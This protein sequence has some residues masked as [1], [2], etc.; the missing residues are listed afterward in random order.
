[1]PNPVAYLMLLIWPF[2]CLGLFR[3][4][5]L[6]RALIWSILGGYLFLPPLAEFNL[7]LVPGLDKVSIPNLS[8]LLIIWL[9]TQ[10]KL[11]LWPASRLAGFLVV[12]LVF[13]AM[14]TVLTNGDPILFQ[15][16]RGFEPILF[17]VD[18]L[19]GLSIRDI[20]SVLIG[21][22]LMLVPFLLARQ[23]LADEEGLRE[24]L[25]AFVIG[26]LI[27]SVPSLFE[28]RFSPQL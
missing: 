19:P 2:V 6:Q 20:G 22:M 5:P 17:P 24:L 16:I 28:V 1:M 14:P 4:L 9:G 23:F 11:Q 13:S 21:Q 18:A 27:Y 3:N 7:P 8:V 26:G 25:L 12:G 10:E 15:A